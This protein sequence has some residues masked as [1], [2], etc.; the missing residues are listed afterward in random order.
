MK[1]LTYSIQINK[2]RDFVFNKITDKSVYP[3]W[4]KA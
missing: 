1:K 4:A 3:Q 2:L